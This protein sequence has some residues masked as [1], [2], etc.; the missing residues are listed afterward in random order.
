[1]PRVFT[2]R[3]AIPAE[4]FGE[5]LQA[6]KLG[7][8]AYARLCTSPGRHHS[9]PPGWLPDEPAKGIHRDTPRAH[10]SQLPMGRLALNVILPAMM[11]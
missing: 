3:V 11:P 9:T 10:P 2:G 8:N 6:R 4:Q 1:M 5:Y 7:Q